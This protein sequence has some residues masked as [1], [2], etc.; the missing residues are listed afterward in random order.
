MAVSVHRQV[1]KNDDGNAAVEGANSLAEGS[2]GLYHLE[3]QSARRRNRRKSRSSAYQ[4]KKTAQ[5]AAES[6][7]NQERS[8]LKKLIQKQRIKKEYA[9]AKQ[10]EQA[11]GTAAVGTID[12]IKKIGGK[13]TNFFKEHRK[14]Y[15]SIAAL[16][17]MI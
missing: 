16:I 10:S 12:Y 11:M 7:V 1:R 2:E 8:Y 17:G 15:I 4:A 5:A 14:V 3:Q 9:K 13:V 6:S